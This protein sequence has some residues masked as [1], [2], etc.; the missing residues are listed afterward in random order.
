MVKQIKSFRGITPKEP[1]KSG[2]VKQIKSYRGISPSTKTKTTQRISQPTNG[3]IRPKSKFQTQYEQKTAIQNYNRAMEKEPKATGTVEEY[4]TNVN[5]W[6][7]KN[8]TILENKYNQSEFSKKIT[9]INKKI[10]TLKQS[11]VVKAGVELKKAIK[12]DVITAAEKI[13]VTAEKYKQS[14][15]TTKTGKKTF[16]K[17]IK[18]YDQLKEQRFQEAIEQAPTILPGQSGYESQV[19]KWTDKYKVVSLPEYSVKVEQEQLTQKIKI[20]SSDQNYTVKKDSQ[21]NI[22]SITAKAKS[23]TSRYKKRSG[24]KAKKTKATYVPYELIF[25]D[26]KVVKEIERS[27]YDEE[28]KK[29]DNYS[30]YNEKVYDKSIKT[31]ADG[32]VTSLKEYDT[33]KEKQKDYT[34][35]YKRDYDTFLK[36][37]INYSELKKTEYSK[38]GTI[39]K[40][41]SGPQLSHSESLAKHNADALARSQG[42]YHATITSGGITGQGSGIVSGMLA[43]GKPKTV[44]VGLDVSKYKDG[45]T[46]GEL[47]KDLESQKTDYLDVKAIKEDVNLIQD[48]KKSKDDYW[49]DYQT[50][51]KKERDTIVSGVMLAGSVSNVKAN[52]EFNNALE[53]KKRMQQTQNRMGE[54]DSSYDNTK[55]SLYPE[56]ILTIPDQPNLTMTMDQRRESELSRYT[57]TKSDSETAKAA[58][59]FGI[60]VKESAVDL[61]GK[62]KPVVVEGYEKVKDYV[63]TEY[64]AAKTDTT[65]PLFKTMF[66]K[67]VESEGRDFTYDI[68][69]HPIQRIKTGVTEYKA[70]KEKG[71]DPNLGLLLTDAIR[72]SLT[73]PSKPYTDEKA[74]Y[75]TI[76]GQEYKSEYDVLLS[77]SELWNPLQGVSSVRKNTF[78]LGQGQINKLLTPELPTDSDPKDSSTVKKATQEVLREE[79]VKQLKSEISEFTAG[80][81][82][83]ENL[84]DYAM[85]TGEFL[86]NTGDLMYDVG[87]KAVTSKLG[88]SMLPLFLTTESVKATAEG[89]DIKKEKIDTKLQNMFQDYIPT[90]KTI[91][92]VEKK[93]TTKEKTKQ[94]EIDKTAKELNL[95]EPMLNIETISYVDDS[96]KLTTKEQV[97]IE[98]EADK[99]IYNK[100]TDLFDKYDQQQ[101]ELTDISSERKSLENIPFIDRIADLGTSPKTVETVAIIGATAGVSGV[102]SG[103]FKTIEGATA[104]GFLPKVGLKVLQFGGRAVKQVPFAIPYAK[105]TESLLGSKVITPEQA[106][107]AYWLTATVSVPASA[108][109]GAAKDMYGK[110]MTKY[111]NW[112]EIGV[113]VGMSFAMGALFGGGMSV[114]SRGV[115]KGIKGSYKTLRTIFPEKLATTINKGLYF[116]KTGAVVKKGTENLIQSF[117]QRQQVGEVLNVIRAVGSDDKMSAVGSA[118]SF[119]GGE[120]GEEVGEFATNKFLDEKLYTYAGLNKHLFGSAESLSSDIKFTNQAVVM[121]I[122][123]DSVPKLDMLAVKDIEQTEFTGKDPKDVKLRE[124][125]RFEKINKKLLQDSEYAVLGGSRSTDAQEIR[126][127]GDKTDLFPTIKDNDIL[128]QRINKNTGKKISKK[129]LQQVMDQEITNKALEYNKAV[130]G[131]NK[132]K[133]T[134]KTKVDSK[135]KETVIKS[136]DDTVKIK[137]WQTP[138]G[139]E[140]N[141]ISVKENNKWRELDDY[142]INHKKDMKYLK[143]GEGILLTTPDYEIKRKFAT[144][145]EE[146]TITTR[147]RSKDLP[148]AERYMQTF[149]MKT[150]GKDLIDMDTLGSKE[151][152][153]LNRILNDPDTLK[154]SKTEIK[155]DPITYDTVMISRG[156][157]Q[158]PFKGQTVMYGGSPTSFEAGAGEPLGSPIGYFGVN[159]SYP[160]FQRKGPDVLMLKL[161]KGDTLRGINLPSFFQTPAALEPKKAAGLYKQYKAAQIIGDIDSIYTPTIK[162]SGSKDLVPFDGKTDP[163]VIIDYEKTSKKKKLTETQVKQLKELSDLKLTEKELISKQGK[164]YR[165]FLD[166]ELN[167]RGKGFAAPSLHTVMGVSHRGTVATKVEEEYIYFGKLTGIKK[168]GAMR[169]KSSG[170][171]LNVYTNFPR[172]MKGEKVGK[173]SKKRLTDNLAIAMRDIRSKKLKIKEFRRNPI[174]SIFGEGIKFSDGTKTKKTTKLKPSD[175]E[176]MK[177]SEL[178]QLGYE[179][180][181]LAIMNSF[182]SES[183]SSS[184]RKD[185]LYSDLFESSKR[186]SYGTKRDSRKYKPTRKYDKKRR[187][188]LDEYVGRDVKPREYKPYDKIS[189]ERIRPYKPKP[190]DPYRPDPRDPREPRRPKRPRVTEL[191]PFE[192]EPRDPRRPEPR[193]PREPRRPEY[194]PEV[195]DQEGGAWFPSFGTSKKK[196]GK[197]KK[198]SKYTERT[199]GTLDLINPN[200]KSKNK[201]KLL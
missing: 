134:T 43:R 172:Y 47:Y 131:R 63:V 199:F 184:K 191:R 106:E 62:V 38:P 180:K 159:R 138:E 112:K 3:T 25:K 14:L 185:P 137:T 166:E 21:G 183:K 35:G 67:P 54:I 181:E 163:T 30:R 139:L 169:D 82:M 152:E 178:K 186:G 65:D 86:F 108:G 170:K 16:A 73:L 177:Q 44:S 31:Y 78:L 141:T 135:G 175:T 80:K 91:Y 95:L 99:K 27:I 117:F 158:E 10:E 76:T 71:L 42:T 57:G 32:K 88:Q 66:H 168:S 102:I 60:A 111:E 145:L 70:A 74:G 143:T 19:K 29:T 93:I 130:G 34:D 198:K 55:I 109:I 171:I 8:K 156:T 164:E 105:A 85:A 123:G 61:Y 165:S 72:P 197:K 192:Y 153:E 149:D 161:T 190:Y 45:I 144:S 84:P 40:E 17:T 100:Y 118:L 1:V 196:T 7:E 98:S 147:G 11:E 58:K 83:K 9:S 69:G 23:Y 12:S 188:I 18:Q 104:T 146:G 39:R 127:M 75:T 15:F 122:A 136:Y 115:Q 116:S 187:S 22:L 195:K 24:E 140:V 6:I 129:E 48:Y 56:T 128:Y 90:G 160:F 20:L 124:R 151:R 173:F 157:I 107:A 162:T 96:G 41:Y 26:G 89:L 64:T 133:V 49:S 132:P 59:A 114:A 176:S 50:Q 174:E 110:D 33:Y 150:K 81:Y 53:N 51:K 2:A 126:K 120:A 182:K 37:D 103:S 94:L 179:S 121:G 142:K 97:N 101:Q 77:Q 87:K 194:E 148:K 193:K 201:F 125:D 92:A 113:S 79:K 68:L 4:Q 5:S 155:R 200:K 46:A 154:K 52:I 28:K 189:P 119:L 36:T 13:R 167:K